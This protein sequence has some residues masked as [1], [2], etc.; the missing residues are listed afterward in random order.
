MNFNEL[1]RNIN[2]GMKLT[3]RIEQFLTQ[4][5]RAKTL[6]EMRAF[7]TITEGV[8]LLWHKR[9]RTFPVLLVFAWIVLN[10]QAEKE[11]GNPL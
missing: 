4:I 9:L 8:S 6:D 10:F 3:Q 5:K 7:Q 11:A 1:L 2:D